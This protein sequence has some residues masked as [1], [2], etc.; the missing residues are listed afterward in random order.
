MAASA[1]FPPHRVKNE[2]IKRQLNKVMRVRQG[3][4]F[5]MRFS[6]SDEPKIVPKSVSAKHRAP[7]ALP[8]LSL[9]DYWGDAVG[10]SV[11]VAT[12]VTR[13][14]VFCRAI[15]LVGFRRGFVAIWTFATPSFSIPI[16][17]AAARERSIFRPFTKGP[18]SLIVTATDFP[19]SMLVT[20]ALVPRG[21]VGWA[22][23]SLF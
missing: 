9:K 11:R 7:Y 5:F 12:G 16:F 18:R 19:V 15:F 6:L 20:T 22:A 14:F 2:V 10:M 21:N 1:N 23:V 13:L 17:W 3:V 4:D 8:S